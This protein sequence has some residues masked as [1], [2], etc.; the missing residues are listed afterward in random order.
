MR[1]G[2]DF[3]LALLRGLDLDFLFAIFNCTNMVTVHVVAVFDSGKTSKYY[4]YLFNLGKNNVIYQ[5]LLVTFVLSVVTMKT[6]SIG[7][8]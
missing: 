4:H 3:S 7:I 2:L 8:Q 5:K 6:Y 1:S